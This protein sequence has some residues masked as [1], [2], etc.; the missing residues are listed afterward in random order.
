MN[1]SSS[2]D[3]IYLS[4]PHL[5]LPVAVRGLFGEEKLPE[6][7]EEETGPGAGWEFAPG[8]GS[9]LHPRRAGLR[10]IPWPC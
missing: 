5:T 1:G 6:A 2:G 10:D 4:L 8:A 9:P 3:T 7:G